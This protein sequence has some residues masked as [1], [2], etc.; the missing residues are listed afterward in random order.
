MIHYDLLQFIIIYKPHNLLPTPADIS[1]PSLKPNARHTVTH[2]RSAGLSN[3]SMDLPK[4]HQEGWQTCQSV[5]TTPQ[6]GGWLASGKKSPRYYQAYSSR[7]GWK[8]VQE[9]ERQTVNVKWDRTRLSVSSMI[10]RGIPPSFQQRPL[11]T[12]LQESIADKY[13]PPRKRISISL[14]NPPAL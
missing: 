9:E 8:L 2:S 5:K 7:T 4:P 14:K 12:Q 10:E 6:G 11:N 13:I 1:C 3:P